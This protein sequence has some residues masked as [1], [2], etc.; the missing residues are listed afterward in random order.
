MGFDHREC[1]F[2]PISLP[3]GSN[4]KIIFTYNRNLSCQTGFNVLVLTL[5]ALMNLAGG[6]G[7]G[8]A[9]P[10]TVNVLPISEI[11]E[12]G[13]LGIC[14]LGAGELTI[15]GTFLDSRRLKLS[16]KLKIKIKT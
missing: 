2:P 16:R 9:S 11:F 1:A 15:L 6:Q 7:P 13:P 4:H 14:K 8:V 12:F 10:S 5:V 3:S